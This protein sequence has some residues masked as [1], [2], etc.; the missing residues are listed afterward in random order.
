MIHIGKLIREK[1]IERKCTVV[2]MARQLSCGRANVYKIFEKYSI[3]TELLMKISVTLDYDFFSLYSRELNN[4]CK[5][6]S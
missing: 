5:C 1:M 3:D 4:K 6:V 2:S